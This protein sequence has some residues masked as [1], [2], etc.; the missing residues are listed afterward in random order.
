MTFWRR[1]YLFLRGLA[2]SSPAQP[3]PVQAPPV[4]SPFERWQIRRATVRAQ[5]GDTEVEA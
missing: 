1:L 4:L 3:E 5:L 2:A